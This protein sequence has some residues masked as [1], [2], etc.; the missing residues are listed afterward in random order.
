MCKPCKTRQI[1]EDYAFS[2]SLRKGHSFEGYT[3]DTLV[4]Y[5]A[6]MHLNVAL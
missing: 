1:P 4:I 6:C 5:L 2:P 3:V